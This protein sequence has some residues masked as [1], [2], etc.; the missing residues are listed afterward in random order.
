MVFAILIIEGV[1]SYIIKYRTELDDQYGILLKRVFKTC[2]LKFG[3]VYFCILN[4]LTAP[5]I[6]SM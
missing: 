2:L 6:D 3:K 4:P 1:S 5:C